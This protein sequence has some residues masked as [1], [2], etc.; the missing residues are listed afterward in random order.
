MPAS[1]SL[2]QPA[3]KLQT[4]R[5]TRLELEEC[6]LHDAPSFAAQNANREHVGTKSSEVTFDLYS[7]R[8]K[9][10]T[11]LNQRFRV[12]REFIEECTNLFARLSQNFFPSRERS[13]STTPQRPSKQYSPYQQNP[14]LQTKP[15]L[16]QFYSPL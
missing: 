1:E 2:R 14:H 12:I 9:F 11:F 7:Q 13:G 16:I 15:L 10:P 3:L 5:Q 6:F 8:F 4:V